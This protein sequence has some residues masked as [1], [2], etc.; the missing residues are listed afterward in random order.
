MKAGVSDINKLDKEKIVSLSVS[1]Q[2][3]QIQNLCWAFLDEQTVVL[4]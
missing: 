1:G 4:Y 2:N 3:L